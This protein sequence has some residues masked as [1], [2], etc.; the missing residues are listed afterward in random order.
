MSYGNVI[1]SSG[2]DTLPFLSHPDEIANFDFPQHAVAL[3][4]FRRFL[5]GPVEKEILR[6]TKKNAPKEQPS[7]R[8]DP[9][10]N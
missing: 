6:F 5:W 9:H 8:A 7:L 10:Q 1:M 2:W 3:Q 4:R